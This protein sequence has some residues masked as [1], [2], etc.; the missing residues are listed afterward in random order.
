MGSIFYVRK[1]HPGNVHCA[2]GGEVLFGLCIFIL[3]KSNVHVVRKA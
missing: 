3:I 1:D 2:G